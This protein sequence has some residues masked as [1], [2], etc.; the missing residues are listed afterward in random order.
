ML[1]KSALSAS[2]HT[3]KHIYTAIYDAHTHL[4]QWEPSANCVTPARST[5]QSEKDA[6]TKCVPHSFYMVFCMNNFPSLQCNS[7][8]LRGEKVHC[9]GDPSWTRVPR[10]HCSS[11]SRMILMSF[12]HTDY[13]QTEQNDFSIER[14]I[15]THTHTRM[16]PLCVLGNDVQLTL[17]I[18]RERMFCLLFV[19]VQHKSVR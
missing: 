10:A 7:P 15:H 17:I 4:L 14:T 6:V 18:I 8:L 13:I 9:V 5:R 11:T 1:N 2:R 3:H 19:A 16:L 12:I